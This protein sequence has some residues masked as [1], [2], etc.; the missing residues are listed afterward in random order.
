MNYIKINFFIF[1]SLITGAT[2]NACYVDLYINEIEKYTGP[3]IIFNTDDKPEKELPNQVSFPLPW[4]YSIPLTRTGNTQWFFTSAIEGAVPYFGE[5][6]AITNKAITEIYV[7]RGHTPN[8]DWFYVYFGLAAYPKF[9]NESFTVYQGNIVYIACKNTSR[10]H[11][12]CCYPQNAQYLDSATINLE[13][14]KHLTNTTDSE[15]EEFQN[16]LTKLFLRKKDSY[17]IDGRLISSVC[18][19]IA[20]RKKRYII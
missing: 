6:V 5:A 20:N 19:Q 8:G 13:I 16:I 1:I 10:I 3:D 12:N 18:L 17:Y 9:H 11:N 7:V 2:L 15:S 14:K 4:L